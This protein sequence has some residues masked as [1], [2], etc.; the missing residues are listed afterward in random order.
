MSFWGSS[1]TYQIATPRKSVRELC[2]LKNIFTSSFDFHGDIFVLM[3]RIRRELL[4]V[5]YINY[6]VNMVYLK[7]IYNTFTASSN[8]K[9]SYFF[10]LFLI[11]WTQAG[12]SLQFARFPS[13]AQKKAAIAAA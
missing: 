6:F 9:T 3:S 13:F 7:I 8:S 12:A 10:N 5:A 1:A 4:R 2:Y 11:S